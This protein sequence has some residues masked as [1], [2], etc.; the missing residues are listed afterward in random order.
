[1][2]EADE[3]QPFHRMSSRRRRKLWSLAARAAAKCPDEAEK[4][5]NVSGFIPLE[6]R[7]SSLAKTQDSGL[8]MDI[9]GGGSRRSTTS[10]GSS[11]VSPPHRVSF[12]VHPSRLGA[13]TS[14]LKRARPPHRFLSDQYSAYQSDAMDQN[15]PYPSTSVPLT[16]RVRPVSLPAINP[17]VAASHPRALYYPIRRR[18]ATTRQTGSADSSGIGSSLDWASTDAANQQL[19]RFSAA[20]LPLPRFASVGT[21][22]RSFDEALVRGGRIHPIVADKSQ[23]QD[24]PTWHPPH[25][26]KAEIVPDQVCSSVENAPTVYSRHVGNISPILGGIPVNDPLL[27]TSPSSRITNWFNSNPHPHPYHEF[28][29]SRDNYRVSRSFDQPRPRETQLESGSHRLVRGRRYYGHFLSEQDAYHPRYGPPIYDPLESAPS[30]HFLER[31]N[32][33]SIPWAAESTAIYRGETARSHTLRS[34]SIDPRIKRYHPLAMYSVPPPTDEDDELSNEC[35][36]ESASTLG[37]RSVRTRGGD[38]SWFTRSHMNRLSPPSESV[39]KWTECGICSLGKD[40]QRSSYRP[41]SGSIGA[42]IGVLPKTDDVTEY[43]GGT[44]QRYLHPSVRSSLCPKLKPVGQTIAH[45]MSDTRDGVVPHSSAPSTECSIKDVSSKRK[46]YPSRFESER[47]DLS[48]DVDDD[49]RPTS[50]EHVST[51]SVRPPIHRSS[52]SRPLVH[53]DYVRFGGSRRIHLPPDDRRTAE[54]VSLHLPEMVVGVKGP[55]YPL[56]PALKKTGQSTSTESQEQSI[57]LHGTRASEASYRSLSQSS[58]EDRTE[59]KITHSPQSSAVG[60]FEPFIITQASQ[61]KPSVTVAGRSW[62]TETPSRTALGGHTKVAIGTMS[63]IVED[64]VEYWDHKIFVRARIGAVTLAGIASIC[65]FYTTGSNTWIYQ[66]TAENL[67]RSGFWEQCNYVNKTCEL[68]IPFVVHRAGWQDG[69]LCILLFAVLLGLLGT[70][71]SIAGHFVFVM[72]KRLYYFHSSGETHV[73]AAMTTALS[74]GVY[75]LTSVFHL[76]TTGTVS[77]G[78]AFYIS[79]VGC[80]LHLLVAFLLFIDEIV[81]RMATSSINAKLVRSVLRRFPVMHVQ[82]RQNRFVHRSHVK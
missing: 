36:E 27:P 37:G 54:P 67:T 81:H 79:W 24:R 48:D 47:S 20:H 15:I 72:S 6:S 41:H 16:T 35:I 80:A 9:H 30:G 13:T 55:V 58:S 21:S 60:A 73:V 76:H 63:S 75:Y 1:M 44:L 82:S 26:R 66:G 3:D 11:F 14:G 5:T 40:L 49:T 18:Q 78:H 31:V 74:A 77:F 68:T 56:R 22:A 42:R 59:Y 71:L 52:I 32:P 34:G 62:T 8:S 65:L 23:L 19:Y 4:P 28:I 46:L 64:Y 38:E 61:T 70:S 45:T 17:L 51:T 7:K 53:P 33:F 10:V 39:T 57:T 12:D 25:S 50:S 29:G 69:A 2:E 43:D